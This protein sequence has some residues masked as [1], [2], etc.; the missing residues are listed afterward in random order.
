MDHGIG[1]DQEQE[2]KLLHHSTGPV[3][4][5]DHELPCGPCSNASGEEIYHGPLGCPDPW[6]SGSI[7]IE[8]DDKGAAAIYDKMNMPK[9]DMLFPKE[10]TDRIKAGEPP[11]QVQSDFMDRIARSAPS[12]D[13]MVHRTTDGPD[14]LVPEP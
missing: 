9:F 1:I 11:D 14:P 8:P 5:P 2:M 7:M 12:Y 13:K 3:P 6:V 4:E 10:F